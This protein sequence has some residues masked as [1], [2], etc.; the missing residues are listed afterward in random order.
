MDEHKI[1]TFTG[2]VQKLTVAYHRGKNLRDLLAPTSLKLVE[3]SKPSELVPATHPISKY[4][5]QF[6]EPS[7]A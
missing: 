4:V 1:F 6:S 5:S 3:G 2:H 7:G